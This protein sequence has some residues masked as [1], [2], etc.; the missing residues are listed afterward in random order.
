MCD[1]TDCAHI[2]GSLSTHDLGGVGEE[3]RDVF[4]VLR[5]EFFVLGV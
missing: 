1:M 2:E 4:V 5:L 3:F